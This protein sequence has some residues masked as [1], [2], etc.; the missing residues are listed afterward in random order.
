MAKA[1]QSFG[2]KRAFVVHSEG[3]DEMSPLGPGHILEVTPDN[4][5]ELSYDPFEFRIPRCSI[6]DLQGGSPEYNAEVLK[7][8]L[9]GDYGIIIH[10]SIFGTYKKKTV[11]RLK[12]QCWI[13]G[14]TED[15]RYVPFLRR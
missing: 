7:R 8:V 12:L 14:C 4:I 13:P 6:R 9:S 2:M 5:Y 1:L 10:F 15:F 3:L 11:K